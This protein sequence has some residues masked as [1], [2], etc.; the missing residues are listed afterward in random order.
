MTAVTASPHPEP[1]LMG[2]DLRHGN[3]EIRFQHSPRKPEIPHARIPCAEWGADELIAIE[4]DESN[5]FVSKTMPIA[6]L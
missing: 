6:T 5:L 1:L 4:V 2:L 3:Q